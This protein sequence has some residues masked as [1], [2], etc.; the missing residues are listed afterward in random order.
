MVK[1]SDFVQNYTYPKKIVKGYLGF[2]PTDERLKDSKSVG[3]IL[4]MNLWGESTEHLQID[5]SP[6]II[7]PAK[8]ISLHTDFAK[9][10]II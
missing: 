5:H 9:F 1:K 10:V 7:C 4:G 2:W 6:K 8:D 3:N